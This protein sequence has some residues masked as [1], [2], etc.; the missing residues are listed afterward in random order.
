[1]KPGSAALSEVGHPGG[2]ACLAG[3]GHT[4]TSTSVVSL[5]SIRVDL[6]GLVA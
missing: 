4:S 5:L 6:F 3:A 1:M 2:Q